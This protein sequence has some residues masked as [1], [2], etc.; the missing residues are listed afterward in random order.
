MC[1]CLLSLAG[2]VVGGGL[3][4]ERE[5]PNRYGIRGV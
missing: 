3:V 1:D 4:Q 5:G 2:I